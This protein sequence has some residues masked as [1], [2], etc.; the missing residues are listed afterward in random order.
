MTRIYLVAPSG[1]AEPLPIM[2]PFMELAIQSGVKRFVLLSAS[3][4]EAGGPMMGAVHTWLRDHSAEWVVLRPTWFMQ[5]F[6][7]G[8][9]LAPIREDRAIYSATGDGRIGF[10]DADD[11]AT[12][13]VE[14]LTQTTCASGDIILTGPQALSYDD[15]AN[16]L[17]TVLD[18]TI[19][20]HHLSAAELVARH[21]QHANLPKAYAQTLAQMDSN[22][23]AGSE[24]RTTDAVLLM[25]GRPPRVLK[26]F[27][28]ANADV[29]RSE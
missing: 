11:I 26:D 4:L 13:A 2:I 20:H 8:Q 6:S 29:W 18:Q 5:N 9:L 7:E 27:V 25:T 1:V 15:V 3:S 21:M 10:I 12:V 16:T 19:R 17:S 14:A 24:D 22:I 28:A 23:A